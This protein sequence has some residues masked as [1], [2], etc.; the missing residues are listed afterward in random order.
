MA[1][2]VPYRPRLTREDYRRLP[3]GPPYYELID[4]ELVEMTRPKRPH[5]QAAGLL[6]ELLGPH[7]R[8]TH[9]GELALEPNLYLPGIEE[10]YHPDLAYVA[11]LRRSMCKTDGI[12]GVP[13]LLCEVLS[14]STERKDRGVKLEDY[15]RAGVPHVWLVTPEQPVRIE[16]FV[17]AEDGRYRLNAVVEA[18]AEW[19]PAIFPGWRLPLAELDAAV[20][21]VQ[22]EDED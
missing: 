5:Y 2:A 10:V 6:L 15:R 1:V 14:R 12:E 16:E 13:D 9:G 11:K 17:L 4:G 22:E 19:E 21:P 7:A 20:A 8:R 3:E 18:P